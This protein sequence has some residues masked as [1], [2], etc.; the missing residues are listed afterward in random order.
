MK[1]KFLITVLSILMVAACDSNQSDETD[2]KVEPASKVVQA[3]TELASPADSEST[4]SESEVSSTVAAAVSTEVKPVDEKPVEAQ[5][6]MSGEQV[7][8]KSCIGC[9][10][11]GAAGSPKLGDV[12]AWKARIAKGMDALYTSALKGV[13]GT[14]MMPKGTCVACSD[15]E[16]KAAVD[17]MVSKSK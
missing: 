8:K 2:T 3:T 11:S 15:A 5:V 14:A 6:E 16:L 7:Y 9:H 4:V 13:A 10:A 17:Y 12:A 1:I